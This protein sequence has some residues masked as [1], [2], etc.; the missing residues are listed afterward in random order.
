MCKWRAGKSPHRDF[1]TRS[2]KV[3]DFC[4][5]RAQCAGEPLLE[6]E[7][8]DPLGCDRDPN[9]G[10]HN[11]AQLF[12]PCGRRFLVE[13]SRG[14]S[15]VLGYDSFHVLELSRTAY[16][17]NPMGELVIVDRQ[18]YLWILGQRLQFGSF[19]RTRHHDLASV[20]VKPDRHHARRA[21]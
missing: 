14:A 12:Q 2:M 10:S 4:T 15:F 20:P 7:Q 16:E 8:A 9:H 19:W 11:P 18:R 3:E 6:V 5:L 21:V 1:P 13:I 17:Q